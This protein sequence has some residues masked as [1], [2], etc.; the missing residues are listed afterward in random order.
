MY[1]FV[2]IDFSDD[3]LV[4]Q[5]LVFFLAGFTGVATALCF[6]LAELAMNPDVQD[7]LYAEIAEVMDTLDSDT[8]TYEKLQR[9]KYLDCVVSETLRK[10]SINI[11]TD[12]K[13]T[14]QYVL[15]DQEGTKVVLQPGDSVWIPS[16]S[17]H[18][19]PKYYPD[20]LAFRPE[21]F[22]PN[23]QPPVNPDTYMPFGLGPRA[24]VASRFA[25]M[26]L[27]ATIFYVVKAFEAR[28]GP[29]SVVPIKLKRTLGTIEPESGFIYQLRARN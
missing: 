25:L 24:C 21:R 28:L 17:I 3:D 5:S 11:M 14:K 16:Y 27:K 18:R 4:A 9:M 19:D 10:W 26:Q 6:A 20:P 13:V 8:I 12:R 22:L 7:K 23:A 15:D 1:S 29:N 2:L